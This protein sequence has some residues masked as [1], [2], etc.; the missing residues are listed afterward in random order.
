MAKKN[1]RRTTM[2]T[3][4]THDDQ[5][6]CLLR[7]GYGSQPSEWDRIRAGH[8]TITAR[9][10]SRCARCG[11]ALRVGEQVVYLGNVRVGVGSSVL[12]ANDYVCLERTGRRPEWMDA[13]RVGPGD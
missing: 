11:G 8:P 3:T 4:T 1:A 10:R 7:G 9:Y 12:H 6:R 5:P 2:T 13:L